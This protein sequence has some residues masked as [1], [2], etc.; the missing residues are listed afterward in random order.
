MTSREATLDKPKRD[1]GSRHVSG[2]AERRFA[3]HGEL[4]SSSPAARTLSK[5]LSGTSA[6]CAAAATKGEWLNQR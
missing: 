2:P 4:A 1:L 3:G 5:S 6:V